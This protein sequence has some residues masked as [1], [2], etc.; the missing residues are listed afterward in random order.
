MPRFLLTA[1]FVATA[2]LALA[3]AAAANEAAVTYDYDGSFDDAVF[4]LENA[5]IGRGLVVDH[6]SHTGE[7]LARTG[8]DLGS[9]VEIFAAADVYL[10]CS[11]KLSREVMEADPTNIVHCPYSIYVADRDGTV[12]LGHRAYPEGEMQKVQTLLADIVKEAME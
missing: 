8:A 6:V 1:G 4:A 10:F 3:G 12:T 5:I 2:T 7:M 9:D 11:A